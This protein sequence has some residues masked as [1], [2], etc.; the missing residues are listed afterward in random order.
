MGLESCGQAG[1]G[2]EQQQRWCRELPERQGE[3]ERE[4][5]G[6]TETETER[7]RQRQ[8]ETE[9]ETETEAETETETETETE[10]ERERD[11][12]RDRQRQRQRQR[13]RETETETERAR[14]ARQGGAGLHDLAFRDDTYDVGGS[15]NDGFRFLHLDFEVKILPCPQAGALAEARPA[16][17]RLKVEGECEGAELDCQ[18][19]CGHGARKQENTEEE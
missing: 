13:Q 16:R 3:R 9:R 14:E 5:E 7:Q 15:S 8:R 1:R 12:D 4:R 10:R 2:H 11:R 18:P 17:G 6:E 19:G